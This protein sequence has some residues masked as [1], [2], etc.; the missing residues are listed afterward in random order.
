M[1][2]NKDISL[3]TFLFSSF[4]LCL[5]IY[6][7]AF[8]RYKIDDLNNVYVYIFFVSFILMQLIEYFIWVFIKNPLYNSIF[9]ALAT[10]LLMLQ[11]IATIMLISNKIVKKRLLYSYLLYILP[12]SIYRFNHI[13]GVNSSV[14]KLGHLKWNTILA[15]ND[16]DL[17]NMLFDSIWLFFF[18][19]PL[20][21]EGYNFALIFGLLTLMLIIYNFYNDKTIGSM[22]CWIVNSIMI[23]YA[24]YL[25]IY[26]PYF[27]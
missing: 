21:Y 6:N 14:S 13:T 20:F 24:I 23:Y 4:I 16:L 7:N 2:W 22:W 18:L 19:F 15:N 17:H 9:T 10:L 8:T 12:V 1:C 25:L 26:L 27:N 3:N 11:P 5:I